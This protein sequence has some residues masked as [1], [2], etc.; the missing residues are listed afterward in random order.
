ML[1]EGL[2][3]R[4]AT[5]MSK[6]FTRRE[7]D[8]GRDLQKSLDVPY[9]GRGHW[10]GTTA[11]SHARGVFLDWLFLESEL[12]RRY[13]DY[14]EMDDFP[15]GTFSLNVYA[16]DATVPNPEEGDR[17]I[18]VHSQDRK[19]ED[20]L[21]GVLQ[22]CR[23]N[24]LS[25]QSV[26]ELCKYGNLYAEVIVRD[27]KT[28]VIGLQYMPAPTVRRIED[29]RRGLVGFLQDPNGAIGATTMGQFGSFQD[30]QKRDGVVALRP[31]EVIHWRLRLKFM[32]S[33]YGYSILEG[34][35]PAWKRLAMLEDAT[36][37]YKFERAHQR[38]AFSVDVG[39]V[40]KRRQIA[41][42]NKAR[43]MLR[44]K[45][46]TNQNG[47]LD[48]RRD[49]LA[50]DEDFFLPSKDGRRLWDVD[51]LQSPDYSETDTF[52][53]FRQK[54]A[55]G[56]NIP[57]SRYGWEDMPDSRN[58]LSSVSIEFARAVMHVQKENASGWEEIFRRHLAVTRKEKAKDAGE[59]RAKMTVPSQI[60]ELAR[61]EVLSARADIARSMKEDVGLKQ[62]LIQVYNYSED[63]AVDIMKA[64]EKEML[65]TAAVEGKARKMEMGESRLWNGSRRFSTDELQSR[66]R[67]DA[68]LAARV[69]RISGLLEDIRAVA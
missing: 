52:R 27:E 39:G 10:Y 66:I 42:L 62:V 7:K 34:A 43:D 55:T 20:E 16:W 54:F 18:W 47:M 38:F 60:L 33:L 6:L 25:W 30:L 5:A 64:R 48:L 15:E 23:A 49:V 21:T 26:R 19:L 46:I 53:M 9:V 11:P 1:F 40:D 13:A 44:R 65:A 8:A 50:G 29:S 35:R 3:K 32:N 51:L 68:A 59:F 37:L 56:V 61:M 41:E 67:R 69:D 36:L 45:K 58:M 12:L 63:E 57:P 4:A 2:S 14:E 17:S 22:R 28:G 31:E 24:D